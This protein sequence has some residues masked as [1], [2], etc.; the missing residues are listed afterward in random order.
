MHRPDPTLFWKLDPIKHM[1]PQPWV[2]KKYSFYIK[3]STLKRLQIFWDKIK[4]FFR[5][6]IISD[7]TS[8][9]SDYGNNIYYTL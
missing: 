5:L 8:S 9:D 6:M 1:D 7:L 3:K 4:I 2:E